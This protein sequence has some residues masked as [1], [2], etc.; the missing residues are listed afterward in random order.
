MNEYEKLEEAKR[1]I[2]EVQQSL[3]TP[4]A[5]P[6][7]PDQLVWENGNL[8]KPESES[9]GKLV[10][11]LRAD[12]PLPTKVLAKRKDGS[13]EELR[14]EGSDHNGNR[15]HY[16][17]DL[18]GSGYAGKKKDGEVRILYGSMYD[19]I[20]IPGPPKNRYE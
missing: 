15:H 1:L 5:Y 13:Y 2:T 11:L 12:W 10:V 3:V 14:Y 17:G 20:K 4:P 6:I 18:P 8:W 7:A 9:D 16:R 19:S